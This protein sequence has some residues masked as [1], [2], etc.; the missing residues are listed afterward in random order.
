LRHNF[1]AHPLRSLALQRAQRCPAFFPAYQAL[2]SSCGLA[3]GR[4]T[5]LTFL[6]KIEKMNI[7][8]SKK[9]IKSNIDNLPAKEER[10]AGLRI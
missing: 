1:T 4:K 3:G 2:L 6:D 5:Y 9:D 7:V 10:D 8:S